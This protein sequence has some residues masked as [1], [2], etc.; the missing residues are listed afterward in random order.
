MF[1]WEVPTPM[2]GVRKPLPMA[3]TSVSEGRVSQLYLGTAKDA[4]KVHM[5]LV[6]PFVALGCTGIHARP[7]SKTSKVPVLCFSALL[8]VFRAVRFSRF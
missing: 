8:T 7:A 2:Q 5:M 4:R 6:M 1:A 3:A